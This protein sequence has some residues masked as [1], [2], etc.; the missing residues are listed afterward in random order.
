MSLSIEKNNPVSEPLPGA[1]PS[2]QLPST[3]HLLHLAGL[4]GHPE[5]F[6]EPPATWGL[7]EKQGRRLSRQGRNRSSTLLAFGVLLEGGT[8]FLVFLH[9]L[10]SLGLATEPQATLPYQ[11]ELNM[12]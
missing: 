12:G 1:F 9:R 7:L 3:E 10:C 8:G 11:H 6:R 4:L 5:G 2:Q